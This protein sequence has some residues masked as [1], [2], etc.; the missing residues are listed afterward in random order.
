M[1]ARN[2][3]EIN[4]NKFWKFLEKWITTGNAPKK[5]DLD[6]LLTEF[7]F[8]YKG[9]GYR[10]L[11]T[12]KNLLPIDLNDNKMKSFSDSLSGI[13]TVLDGFQYGGMIEDLNYLDEIPVYVDY[14][15]GLDIVKSLN[16]ISKNM[17]ID[18]TFL[19]YIDQDE[20]ISHYNNPKLKY[21]IKSEDGDRLGYQAYSFIPINDWNN[22]IRKGKQIYS[23]QYA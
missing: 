16:Y 3:N 1:R 6:Y 20:I 18:D 5:I 2:V 7:P 11:G 22:G 9:I 23:K 12:P 13:A 4:I 19:Q 17:E 21:I 15:E 8:K 14:I 10:V